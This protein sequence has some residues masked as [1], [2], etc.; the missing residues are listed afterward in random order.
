MPTYYT[1]L[2]ASLPMLQFQ[3]QTPFSFEEF[4]R[5]CDSLISEKDSALLRRASGPQGCE[6][7][8][9]SPVLKRWYSFECGLRNEL[10]KIRAQKKGLD[11]HTYVRQDAA[12][13][14]FVM[15]I[16]RRALKATSPIEAE[17]MLDEARWHYLDE[18]SLGH[19]FDQE[20]L[21]TYALKLLINIRWQS[22]KDADPSKCI[23]QTIA[24]PQP[25]AQ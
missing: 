21:F 4:L 7:V 25:A 19:Y 3:G 20:V 17:K 2:L 1:Y 18:L 15:S 10:A 6:G 24:V 11:A 12:A 23:E 5:R 13:D 9:A 14:S 16:V 8:Q 22:I